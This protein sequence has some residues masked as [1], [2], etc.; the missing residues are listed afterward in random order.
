M[1]PDLRCVD[2]AERRRAFPRALRLA[3]PVDVGPMRDFL[4]QSERSSHSTTG[5][6]T[7]AG[8]TARTQDST[9]AGQADG[10]TARPPLSSTAPDRRS[11]TTAP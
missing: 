5:R 2:L 10:S 1:H 9:S 6:G 4:E 8:S 3:G 7:R 11:G